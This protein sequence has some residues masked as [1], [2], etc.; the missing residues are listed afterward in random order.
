MMKIWIGSR[1]KGIAREGRNITGDVLMISKG[2]ISVHTLNV[3][4]FMDLKARLTYTLRLNTMVETKQIER[5]LLSLLFLLKL[6]VLIC[7]NLLI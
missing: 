4:N 1:V 6:M 5:K 2:S 7:Q 3:R